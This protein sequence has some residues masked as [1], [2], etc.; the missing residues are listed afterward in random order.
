MKESKRNKC[1]YIY[2]SGD[3]MW[4]NIQFTWPLNSINSLLSSSSFRKPKGQQNLSSAGPLC[5]QHK[6]TLLWHCWGCEGREVRQSV[7][8]TRLTTRSV[9]WPEQFSLT[10]VISHYLLIFRRCLPIFCHCLP[11][12]CHC[13]LIFCHCLPILCHYFLIYLF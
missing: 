12:F 6:R 1:R 4:Y 9:S 5:S 8:R 2:Q 13:L 3:F 10:H 11:I 7:S